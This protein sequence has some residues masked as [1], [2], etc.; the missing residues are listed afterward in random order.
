LSEPFLLGEHV[1][2]VGASIGIATTRDGER[3]PM[4][5]LRNA[6]AAMYRAKA[7]GR[8]RHV[9]F[10]SALHED[11]LNR[12]QLAADLR[13]AIDDGEFELHYQPVSSLTSGRVE[14]VEAL[15]RWRRSADN[16]VSPDEFIP[17][18]EEIG[19]MG[20]IGR[21]V[22]REACRQRVEWGI[23]G[24]CADDF[25]ISVNL[26]PKQFTDATLVADVSGI[27]AEANLSPSLLI[28]EITET[29]IIRDVNASRTVLS[30]LRR[31]G[32][33]VALDDFG[34]GYSSLSH[35]SDLPIDTIKIDR[36][37]VGEMCVRSQDALIIEAVIALAHSLGIMTIAEGVE[38]TD[39]LEA[40][41]QRGCDSIQGYLLSRPVPGSLVPEM[42]ALAGDPAIVA[43]ARARA[44]SPLPRSGFLE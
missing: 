44:R 23:Q 9:V 40:L 8:N 21:W 24:Q 17:V 22:L 4:A 26:S 29:A 19:L 28:L 33:R 35:L 14:T 12:L 16:L 25:A 1:A 7:D 38:T 27:L 31:M 36:S 43:V 3:T 20:P 41:R 32:V 6:D 2:F 5:L 42:L 39:Q 30:E 34:T 13:S 18:A 37:F 15:V 11:A 10:T